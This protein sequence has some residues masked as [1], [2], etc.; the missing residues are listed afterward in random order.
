MRWEQ[1]GGEGGEKNSASTICSKNDGSGKCGETAQGGLMQLTPALSRGDGVVP[2]VPLCVWEVRVCAV[3]TKSAVHERESEG[4][5][6]R[7]REYDR[8]RGGGQHGK[9]HT[10]LTRKSTYRLHAA[11]HSRTQGNTWGSLDLRLDET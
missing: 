2:S 8:G 6:E 9:Q 4:A 10:Q 1:L 11:Q 7:G 5:I 3:H